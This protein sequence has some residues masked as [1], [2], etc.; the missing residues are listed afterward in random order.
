MPF[1]A[2]NDVYRSSCLS[3]HSL[4]FKRIRFSAFSGG[5]DVDLYLSR[6]SLQRSF[7]KYFLTVIH[8]HLQGITIVSVKPIATRIEIEA[9]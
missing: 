4:T 8:N 1:G 6:N 9:S 7:Y 2:G 5:L 3:S